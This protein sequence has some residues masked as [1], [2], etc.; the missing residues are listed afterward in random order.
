MCKGNFFGKNKRGAGVY[1][2]VKSKSQPENMLI[3]CLKFSKFQPVY[4]YKGYAYKK[5]CIMGWLSDNLPNL[6]QKVVLFETVIFSV[7]K[8]YNVS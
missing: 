6:H 5:E 8:W 4:A 1:S 2:G 7:I 3:I